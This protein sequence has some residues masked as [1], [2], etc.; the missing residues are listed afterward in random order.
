LKDLAWLFYL[1]PVRWLARILP[2]RCLYALGDAAAFCGAAFLRR[3]RKAL[4]KRFAT[5]FDAS[6]ADPRLRAIARLYFRNA[7]LR[8]FDDLLME[9]AHATAS[10]AECRDSAYGEPHPGPFRWPGRGAEQ[11]TFL[12]QPAGQALPRHHRVSCSVRTAPCA[13]GWKGRA[14]GHALPA[15]TICCSCRSGV[16]R[17]GLQP[18][19]GLQPED[20]CAVALR[21]A[22]R[23]PR[24]R[25]I[26]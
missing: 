11:R 5:A 12:R 8:F 14:P 20:A 2:L 7:I 24:G 1:Y 23:L 3:P 21:W 26:L 22:P 15:E 10:F 17:L 25:S 19:S 9:G 4:L 16:G 18:G 6:A 13:S